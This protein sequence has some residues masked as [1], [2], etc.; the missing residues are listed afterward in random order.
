[1]RTGQLLDHDPALM[2]TKLADAEYEPDATH[3]DVNSVLDCM[4]PAVQETMSQLL[5]AAAS[6][7]TGSDLLAVVALVHAA[8][9][10]SPLVAS[11]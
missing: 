9:L 10:K 2:L 5:G 11:Q 8:T 3:A 7:V 4:A 6:G 1:M